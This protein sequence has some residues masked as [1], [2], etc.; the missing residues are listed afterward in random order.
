[1]WAV[2]AIDFRQFPLQYAMRL[3]API[4]MEHSRTFVPP[5]RIPITK[6]YCTKCVYRW[7]TNVTTL[8]NTPSNQADRYNFV[9]LNNKRNRQSGSVNYKSFGR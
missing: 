1:M 6:R 3:R 2:L 4:P 5:F 7:P 8:R 9:P